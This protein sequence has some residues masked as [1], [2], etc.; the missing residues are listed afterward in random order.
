MK[1]QVNEVPTNLTFVYKH[2]EVK[3]TSLFDY[4]KFGFG[5]YVGYNMART[6]KHFIVKKINK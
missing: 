6:L 1:K 3:E 4:I 5:F 2:K